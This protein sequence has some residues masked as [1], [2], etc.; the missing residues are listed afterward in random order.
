MGKQSIHHRGR[1]ERGEHTRD[2]LT[3]GRRA[4]A[5][6]PVTVKL[7]VPYCPYRR[8]LLSHSLSLLVTNVSDD[9]GAEVNPS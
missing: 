4:D 1:G 7:T 5:P 6:P 2:T 8:R 3:N 9:N